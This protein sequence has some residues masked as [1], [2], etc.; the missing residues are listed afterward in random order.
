GRR[1]NDG[2]PGSDGSHAGGDGARG[3]DAGPAQRGQDGGTLLV[4]LAPGASEHVV[5][6][7]GDRRLADGTASSFREEVSFAAPGFVDLTAVGGR[8]GDGGNGGRGGA[9][10]RGSRGSDATRYS[11]GTDG[12]AG[13]DGGNGGNATSGADG[14]SG[15]RI[16]VEVDQA[17]THLLMLVRQNVHGGDPGHPGRNGSGGG[18]GAGGSGGSSY[19]WTETESYTDSE[20]NSQTRTTSHSNPGGSDGP[21]GSAGYSGNA[22][23]IHGRGGRD[24]SFTIVVDGPD[25]ETEYPSRYEVRL[26]GFVHQS[27]N[28]DG[29]YEPQERVMVSNIAVTNVGGMP[30]PT[31][32]DV[33]VRLEQRGWIIP[34]DA[35]LLVPRGLPSGDTVELDDPLWLTIGDY[36]PHG[37][38]DPLA[39]PETI[40]LRADLPAAQRA[41]EAFDDEV[42]E[43]QGPFVIAFPVETSPIDSLRALAPGEAAHLRFSITNTSTLPLGIDTEGAR[44]VRFTLAAHHSELG[45][46]HAMLL[47]GDGERVPLEDG[48][49]VEIDAIEPGQTLDFEACIGFT[50]DAPLYR[51][52]TLWLTVELGFLERP[53]ELRPV[54]FRAFEARVASRYRRDPAA[55][56]LVVVNHRTTRDE[57][58]AWRALLEELGLKMAIWDLSLQGGID[59]HDP[60]ADGESL[61][62]HFGG[63]S[64]IVLNNEVETPAGALPARRIVGKAQVIAAAEA[65][66]DVL[67]VGKNVG[68]G[69]MLVPTHRQPDLEDEPAEWSMLLDQLHEADR[70][71]LERVVGRAAIHDWDGLGRG[72]SEDKLVKHAQA[73]SER[74]AARYPDLRFT[75]VHDFGARLVKKTLWFKR[76]LLGHVEVRATLPTDAGRLLSV[77]LPAGDL[78]DPNLVRSDETAMAVLLTRSFREKIQLLEA[79]VCRAAEQAL[80]DADPSEKGRD[81]ATLVGLIVDAML[82]DLAEEIRGLVAPGWRACMGYGRMRDH[83]PRLRALASFRPAGGPRLPPGSDAGQHLIRLAA[84]VRRF[85]VAHL[86]FWE[87]LPP[88]L[89]LRRAPSAWWLARGCARDLLVGVF[90]GDEPDAIGK[91]YLK[92]A[93][94]YLDVQER[95]LKSD[96]ESFRKEHQ[97]ERHA[98]H[99]THAEQLLFAPLRRRGVT[100]DGEV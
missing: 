75:V 58:D 57:L 47:D 43:E 37:P 79:A 1:G 69:H 18:G 83:M 60:L 11:W 95:E 55:D 14:G 53:A 44:R 30:T 87:L 89:F 35:H 8:G 23:V 61:L 29:V 73:L 77:E 13:G 25:G 56:V 17:H 50:R 20:G 93:K 39:V 74:L 88:F 90:A 33:E 12:G 3:G 42:A 94:G 16:V 76:W 65:G 19:H 48:W 80:P 2:Y 92:E 24:G 82:V 81:A 99:V 32:S 5:A 46:A 21:S 78:H 68:I 36:R 9:G 67:F 66:I 54:Q 6:L 26:T 7:G 91:A 85:A 98:S 10:A 45:D 40:H 97:R 64:M 86:R 100:S 71:T 22:K 34:E 72:P 63:A 41:F 15:G 62:D 27:E 84:R 52:L 51:S 49:T 38:D 96:F 70:P 59:L 28:A 31:H 4:E